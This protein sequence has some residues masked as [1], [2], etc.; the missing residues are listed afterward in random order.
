MKI[1]KKWNDAAEF[2]GNVVGY[3]CQDTELD[4]YFSKG[5]NRYVVNGNKELTF[6]LISEYTSKWNAKK[7]DPEGYTISKLI[8][9]GA[10]NSNCALIDE[11]IEER[12]GGSLEMRLASHEELK[13]IANALINKQAEFDYDFGDTGLKAV[14]GQLY[15]TEYIE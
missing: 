13:D 3:K 5:E 15:S 14:A 4:Y 12:A 7:G 10:V 2:A 1:I 6:G 11:L 9:K 8:I